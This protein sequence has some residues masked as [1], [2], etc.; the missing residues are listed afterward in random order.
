MP[1]GDLGG[2]EGGE[3]PGPEPVADAVFADGKARNTAFGNFDGR[4]DRLETRGGF[5]D[6]LA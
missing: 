2:G 4:V 1:D 3:E 5:E 6:G